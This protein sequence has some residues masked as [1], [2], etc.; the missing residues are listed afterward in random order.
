MDCYVS[1]SRK[2]NCVR[3]WIVTLVSNLAVFVVGLLRISRKF[4]CLIETVTL[5]FRANLA[6]FLFELLG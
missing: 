3:I 2:L 1:I 4:I 6:V 5:V